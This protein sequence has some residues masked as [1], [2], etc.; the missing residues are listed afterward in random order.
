MNPVLLQPLVAASRDWAGGQ[1]TGAMLAATRAFLAGAAQNPKLI[2]E[3]AASLPLI[4][5]PGSAAW[6]AL[7][8][9]TAVE[10][11]VPPETTGTAVFALMR[12]WLPS[13][14]ACDGAPEEE[15]PEPT[16]EQAVLLALFPFVCQAAVTHLARMPSHRAEMGADAGLLE[17]LDRLRAYSHGAVWAHEALTKTSGALILLH[18]PSR[19]GVRLRFT[20]VS[21]C[22][23]LFSLLQTAV[24]QTLP[25]G[26][27]PNET[28]ARVSRGKSTETVSDEAWWHYGNALANKPEIATSLWGEGLVREIPEI[29]GVRVV[30][31][32]PPILKSRHWD[33]GFMQ[34]HLAAMP[35][36]AV[37]EGAL[38]Q[39]EVD[40]WLERLGL[41]ARKSI[42]Q[43]LTGRV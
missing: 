14:P 43:T 33:T 28:I 2:G 6:L 24:G 34:P 27:E 26:R 37:M 5:S 19:A 1:P 35:A 36:D 41:S 12:S 8:S 40:G 7:A 42:W 22:F 38:T 3:L 20:N 30:L 31:A 17:R 25:G 32:W 4:G 10:S 13:L 23:H 29:D 11:G 16:E 18:P 39:P 9:G 15:L 21:N